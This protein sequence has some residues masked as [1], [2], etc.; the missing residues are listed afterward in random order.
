MNNHLDHVSP[1]SPNLGNDHGFILLAKNIN[2]NLPNL[3]PKIS[4]FGNC[5]NF[6]ILNFV[7][8]KDLNNP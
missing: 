3:I 4:Q 1:T 2:E 8:D 6:K 5:N 7:K